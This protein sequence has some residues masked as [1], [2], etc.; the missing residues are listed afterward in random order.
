MEE[1]QKAEN[2][3]LSKF[4][5]SCQ[6][7]AGIAILWLIIILLL[8]VFESIFNNI[9]HGLKSGFFEILAW[10][11]LLN[12][13]YWLKL[14]F[15][16]FI[17]FTAIYFISARFAR[18]VFQILIVLLSLV[19][20][21]LL[22]YFNTSLVLLGADLYSY[23]IQ[24]IKQTLGASGGVNILSI[25]IFIV[26]IS[27]IIAAL[28]FISHRIKL[29]RFQALFLLV[30]SIIILL[31]ETSDL[32]G[33]PNFKS[34]FENSLIL[35]KSDYFFSATYAHFF[36]EKFEIDIYSENYINDFDDKDAGAIN[37]EYVDEVNYP[38]LH[39]DA[40]QDVLS[41]FFRAKESL[42]NIVIILVEGLGRAYS[43]DGAYLG[44]FT[45]FLDSLSEQSLFWRNML[46][47]GGRT[48]AVLPSILGSLPFGKNGFLDLGK[49]PDQLSLLNLLKF[50]G[51]QT[52]FYYG[53]DANFDRMRQYLQAN[54]VDEIRDEKTFPSGY[55]KL[56]SINGFS[57]G[58]ND[59]ELFRYF[60]SSRTITQNLKP[61]LSVILTV[62]T[63]NPFIIN[64]SE[65]YA[66]VLE[67]QMNSLKF[68]E[69]RKQLYKK[70]KDQYASILY[71]DDA[72]Q[73][74]FKEY[75][76]RPDY[77]NT[78]FIITGDHRMPE[79]PMSTKIDRYHV[80]MIVYSPLLKRTA[81]FS[82]VSSHFDLPPTVL[83]YLKS[84]H[85]IKVPY[86]NSW[87]GE[88]LDTGRNFRNLHRIPL[89]QNKTDIL[90]FVIGE[91]HLNGNDLFRLNPGMDE[92]RINDAAKKNHLLNEFNLFKKRNAV[93]VNGGKIIPD[94]LYKNYTLPK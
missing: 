4:Y 44:S 51:Y 2:R 34:D 62:S 58:Y 88:G 87:I 19:Q 24:D 73:M 86:I 21:G 40:S 10:S 67:K 70:Y 8:S 83:A 65:K 74:F 5:N 1:N 12:F 85:K 84:N 39:K 27:G 47:Q 26:L 93:I 32:V 36:P 54:H 25:S 57:W 63:H 38:F 69:S 28:H 94:T 77:E 23:S 90:D 80:P 41:P 60:L 20:L 14:L 9:S 6:A 66:Q 53:G 45:P 16:F 22:L 13:L 49:M 82:S 29:N 37:F 72:V 91:Y 55:L 64:E 30:M 71:M 61:Q 15:I 50:N 78:I 43:N 17:I 46:S 18:L 68:D 56:P 75:K 3:I 48:F 79:I 33:R 59:K 76:K 81:E 35:N 52:S 92:E 31:T 7:F 42:P 89:M 11:T